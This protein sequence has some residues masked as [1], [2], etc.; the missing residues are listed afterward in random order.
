M[1]FND[2]YKSNL[3]KD[4]TSLAIQNGLITRTD[5]AEDTAKDVCKFF[6]T[7]LDNIEK[8]EANK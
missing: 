6:N 5:N 7:I 8:N 1:K 2:N 3:A 4:L